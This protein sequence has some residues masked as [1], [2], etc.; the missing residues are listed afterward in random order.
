M[1]GKPAALQARLDE[2]DAG[3]EARRQ[4]ERE[5]GIQIAIRQGT[6]QLPGKEPGADPEDLANR[7]KTILVRTI[8]ERLAVT[9]KSLLPMVGLVHGTY[10]C[11]R[12]AMER[13]DRDA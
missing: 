1:E 13:P 9:V 7:E 6:L 8:G 12:D 10:H 5:L 2:L 4:T 11:Q 3:I